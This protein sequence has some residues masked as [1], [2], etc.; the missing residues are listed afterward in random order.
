MQE[1]AVEVTHLL[2][3]VIQET[4][5]VVTVGP[6]PAVMGA[7]S[8]LVQLL[9]NLVS[10]GLKYCVSPTPRIQVCAVH[11]A[12]QWVFSVQ[13][14]GIGIETKHFERIFEVFKRL[15]A[16]T[17]YAGTGIGLAICQRVVHLHG[18][19]I[20]LHSVQGQGSTFYF[21]LP[22]TRDTGAER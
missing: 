8:Q 15:H 3:A 6:L 18:G 19:K 14:N 21:T 13:D 12:S 7:R 22:H 5:A 11:D 4:G 2:D 1:V 20:G 9:L 17:E 16:Q 10:N